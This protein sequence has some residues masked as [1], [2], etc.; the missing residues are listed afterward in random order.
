MRRIIFGII[1]IVACFVC[2]TAAFGLFKLAD[3]VPNIMLIFVVSIA[4]MRGQKE[5]MIAGFFSG[6]LLDIYYSSYLGIFAFVF[7]IFG[8]VDGLFHRIYYA[9]DTFLPLVLIAV[10]DVV[11][12]LLM[13]LGY[14]ILKNHL[15]FLFYLRRIILP[16]IVYT[17]AV[18]MIFYRIFLRVNNWLESHEKGSV[19]FV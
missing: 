4:V 15:H 14:G 5:G 11:Y 3:T 13:Y 8:F 12:G 7:M 1:G 6:L 2:Q 16:E 19:D 10:N 9:E 18:A 17:I